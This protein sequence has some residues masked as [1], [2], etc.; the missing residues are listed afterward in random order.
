MPPLRLYTDFEGGRRYACVV[1][2]ITEIPS[3]AFGNFD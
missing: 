1:L 3:Q 2:G